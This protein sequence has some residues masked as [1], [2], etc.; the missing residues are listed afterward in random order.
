[1]SGLDVFT[2]LVMA[3]LV[4]SVVYALVYLGGWPGRIAR[5]R[6]HPQAEAVNV[7]GWLGLLTGAFW[8]IAMVWAFW[9]YPEPATAGEPAPAGIG[10][11][12]RR[13]EGRLGALEARLPTSGGAGS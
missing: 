12:I 2:F 6:N 11:R 4:G 13:L 10:E 9:R 8:I 7:C 3:V 1:M 5:E